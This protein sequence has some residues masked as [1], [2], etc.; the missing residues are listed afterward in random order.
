MVVLAA[1]WGSNSEEGWVS[2]QVAGALACVADVHVVTPEGASPGHEVDGVFTVHH[3]ATP[4]DPA[5]ELRRDLLVAA[6]SATTTVTFDPMTGAL[7]DLFDEDLIAPWH[8]APGLLAELLPDLVVIV[9]HQNV[10][11][12]IALDDYD[13]A[14][15]MVLLALGTDQ[16][17]LRFPHFDQLFDR[18]QT[19]LAITHAEHKSIVEHHGPENRVHRIGAPLI[20]DPSAVSEPDISVGSSDY[21]LVLTEASAGAAGADAE[22]IQLLRMRFP[23]HPVAVIHPDA[24][25]VWHRG[26]LDKTPP[27]LR[28]S[29]AARL[30]AWARMT[31]DLC[32]G[33]LLARRSLQSLLY[34]TPIVVPHESRAREHAEGGRGGLWFAN[35]VELTW[36]VEAILDPPTRASLSEQG[37]SYVENEYG[38][39]DRFIDRVAQACGLAMPDSASESLAG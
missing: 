5:A 14:L 19:M 26:H 15:P 4:L 2:R 37:R 1:H 33:R 11:A 30:M 3:L 18:A 36:C 16:A 27:V 6:I 32:P 12:R 17:S 35:P 21:V 31:V 7:A 34:G 29:D 9:G 28:S 10:G 20:V 24:L 23:D 38:S 39:T 25:C 8:G 22:L 13:R